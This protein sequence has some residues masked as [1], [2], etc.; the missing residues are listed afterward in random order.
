MS[1]VYVRVIPTSRKKKYYFVDIITTMFI[2]QHMVIDTEWFHDRIKSRHESLR[3]FARML[4]GRHG[5]QFDVGAL[6]LM[7]RGK[8]AMQLDEARQIAKL[9]NVPFM[10]VVVRAIGPVD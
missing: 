1:E 10:E 9:L 3:K 2:L 4:Q 6:S 5:Q 8:R 7:L